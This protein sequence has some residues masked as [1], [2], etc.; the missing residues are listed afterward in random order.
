M[1]MNH[2]MGIVRSSNALSVNYRVKFVF[3]V[4][5]CGGKRLLCFLEQNSFKIKIKLC[6]QNVILWC[7][8]RQAY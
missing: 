6:I 5:G 2:L 1:Y 7:V 4:T 8:R 3:L